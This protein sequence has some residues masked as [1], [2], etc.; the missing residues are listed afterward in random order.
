MSVDQASSIVSGFWELPH[1]G[2][3]GVLRWLDVYPQRQILGAVAPKAL[4]DLERID[5]DILP[6]CHLI[7]GPETVAGD[8]HGRGAP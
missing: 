8:D 4:G 7:A 1:G 3:L 6:P 2:L 5:V